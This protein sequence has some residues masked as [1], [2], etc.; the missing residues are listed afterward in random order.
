MDDSL[1]TTISDVFG[2]RVGISG[3]VLL[4]SAVNEKE[5][6]EAGSASSK[7]VGTPQQKP[8]PVAPLAAALQGGMEA[9]TASLGSRSSSEDQMRSLTA[10]LQQQ[11]EETRRFQEMQLQ[12]L[13]EL[14]PMT[15]LLLRYVCSNY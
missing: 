4:D 8:A 11:Y 7:D 5:D 14:L 15:S 3:E 13:R 2:G 6:E 10:S 1:W 9:I 12:L